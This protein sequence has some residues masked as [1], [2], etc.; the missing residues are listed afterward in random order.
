MDLSKDVIR[1]FATMRE[2]FKDREKHDPGQWKSSMICDISDQDLI[3]NCLSQIFV[4][5]LENSVK[6]LYVLQ[7]KF[8]VQ[9]IRKLITSDRIDPEDLVVIVTSEK[10]TSANV[11][12]LKNMF[13][14]TQIFTIAELLINVTHHVLVPRHEV[15]T[16]K[17]V[18]EMMEVFNVKSK[19]NLPLI[20]SSDPVARYLAL[21]PGQ[22]VR[23]TRSSPSAGEYVGY[24]YCI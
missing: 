24:R 20:L 12:T 8:K 19:A 13:A 15:M 5:P 23:I 22:V 21:R 10:P 17:E 18:A 11:K 9:D 7:A 4:V 3:N 2:M 1:S 14:R 6:I 16:D